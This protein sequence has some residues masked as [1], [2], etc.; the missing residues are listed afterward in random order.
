MLLAV[1]VTWLLV[2]EYAEE[3]LVAGDVL[4]TCVIIITRCASGCGRV[5]DLQSGRCRFESRPGLVHTKVY[6]AF[7]PSRVG[8]WVPAAAGR[9]KA[10]MAHSVCGWNAGCAGKTVI[11]WQ[12]VLYLSALK[13]LR[14]EM[15]YKSTS[16][17]CTFITTT[18]T[19]T[20]HTDDSSTWTQVHL[21][22]WA[23]GT[24]GQQASYT[25]AD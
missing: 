21:N 15:L 23:L 4:F 1:S 5:Q 10:G 14:V 9:T 11:P 18:I 17:T 25:L 20:A 19:T 16:F 6:S 13:K 2:D 24:H 12:C 8:K 7:N 22:H 3:L